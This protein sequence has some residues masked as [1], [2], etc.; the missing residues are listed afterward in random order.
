MLV[1]RQQKYRVSP[2][3]SQRRL[4]G[5]LVRLTSLYVTFRDRCHSLAYALSL[6]S[7]FSGLSVQGLPGS[8]YCLILPGS[9]LLLS[10]LSSWRFFCSQSFFYSQLFFYSYS[11]F[12]RVSCVQSCVYSTRLLI[13]R[14]CRRPYVE[15]Y[16]VYRRVRPLLDRKVTILSICWSVG[17]SVVSCNQSVGKQSVR[18][19]ERIYSQQVVIERR[20]EAEGLIYTEKC[21]GTKQWPILPHHNRNE[22]YIYK[23]TSQQYIRIT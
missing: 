1:R 7:V 3:A 5:S 2:T 11:I 9:L 12:L 4:I 13:Q 14:A 17:R 23:C 19:K 21:Q 15:C 8:P 22:V 20:R 6:M 18:R 16:K 10:R